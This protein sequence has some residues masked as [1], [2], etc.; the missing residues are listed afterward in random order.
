MVKIESI[1][2]ALTRMPV[3]S[4]GAK[5]DVVVTRW[6][7]DRFELETFGRRPTLTLYDAAAM[8]LDRVSR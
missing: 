8:I 4:T 1:M 2:D 5:W 6:G 7:G 3:G